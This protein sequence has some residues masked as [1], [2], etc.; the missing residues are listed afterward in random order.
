MYVQVDCK[1]QTPDIAK[2]TLYLA[3]CLPHVYY[4]CNVTLL[5]FIKTNFRRSQH[6]SQTL[7]E[8]KHANEY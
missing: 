2:T 6:V 8:L 4:L 3:T 5:V 1:G 7:H